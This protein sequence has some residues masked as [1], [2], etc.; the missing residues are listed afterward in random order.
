VD[1]VL[2]ISRAVIAAILADG[3]CALI[4]PRLDPTRSLPYAF[5]QFSFEMAAP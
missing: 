3:K 2:F 5:D 1:L 4:H